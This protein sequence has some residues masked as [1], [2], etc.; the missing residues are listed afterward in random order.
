MAEF[1]TFPVRGMTCAACAARVEAALAR[2]P[3]VK[4]A[5]VNLA[6][7]TAAV[8]VEPAV[9]WAEL[10]RAVRGAGYEVPTETV[11]LPIGGMT[12]AACAAHVEDALRSLPGVVSVSVNLAT[13]KVTVTYIPGTVSLADFRRAVA[14]AGY[15]IREAPAEG[16]AAAMEDEA[17]RK[18][19]ESRF[20]MRVAW[21]F[22]LPIILWM[23]PEMIWGVMWPDQRAFNLG[24]ILLA[25]PVLFWVG[26]RTYR[27]GL[28]AALHGYP[29]MDTLIALGTG[30]SFLTGPLSFF[31][32]IANYAGVSAMIMA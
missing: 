21:A 8:E 23:L 7:E 3:G 1:R 5:A 6:T 13:E 32:P 22:T 18:M 27:S 19:R 24:M 30:V 4:R 26:R 17:E 2:V 10:V 29:N 20:R 15:E 14:E 31:F 25:V 28:A 16:A 9:P 12:C 11:M